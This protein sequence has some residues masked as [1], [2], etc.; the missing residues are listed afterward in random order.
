VGVAVAVAAHAVAGGRDDDND[1]GGGV[2]TPAQRRCNERASVDAAISS[3]GETAGL[4]EIGTCIVSLNMAVSPRD[5]NRQNTE[6][7]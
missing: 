3:A 7:V 5:E 1:E 6:R 4:A 2:T